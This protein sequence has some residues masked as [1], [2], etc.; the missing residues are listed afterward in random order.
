MPWRLGKIP[1]RNFDFVQKTGNHPS[2]VPFFFRTLVETQVRVYPV[3][4]EL[5]LTDSERFVLSSVGVIVDH[6]SFLSRALS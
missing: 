4:K 6:I 5:H 3:L 1:G 2:S